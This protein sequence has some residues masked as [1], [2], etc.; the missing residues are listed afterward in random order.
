MHGVHGSDHHMLALAGS[1]AG[2]IH[3]SSWGVGSVQDVGFGAA[4]MASKGFDNGRG[5]GRHVLGAN[6][7]HYVRDPWGS[8]AE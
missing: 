8:Y 7:F 2:G 4:H 5:L 6:Y 1:C 3:H